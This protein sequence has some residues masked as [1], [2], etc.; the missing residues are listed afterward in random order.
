MLKN[1]QKCLLKGVGGQNSAKFG[2][3]SFWTAPIFTFTDWRTLL[4]QQAFLPGLYFVTLF[5]LLIQW[6]PSENKHHFRFARLLEQDGGNVQK[7]LPMHI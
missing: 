7:S 4:L 5:A 2:L 1:V 3:R 6:I